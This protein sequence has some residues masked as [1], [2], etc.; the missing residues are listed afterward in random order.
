MKKRFVI[1]YILLNIGIIMGAILVIINLI[2]NIILKFNPEAFYAGVPIGTGLTWLL[3]IIPGSILVR[4]HEQLF[5]T[6]IGAIITLLGLGIILILVAV[7]LSG[8]DP[9]HAAL[10]IHPLV[11]FLTPVILP[12]VLLYLTPGILLIS[13]IK[14]LFI[15]GYEFLISGII[16][17]IVSAFI[18]IQ[19][20]LS[21]PTGSIGAEWEAGFAFLFYKFW[22][23]VIILGSI[24]V[25]KHR[26]FVKKLFAIIVIL[27][28]IIPQIL[29]FVGLLAERLREF[30]RL[31]G[32]HPALPIGPEP[33]LILFMLG[34]EMRVPLLLI[35][36]VLYLV[37][38]ILLLKSSK[39][40]RSG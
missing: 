39:Q 26:F 15:I 28:G 33:E 10:P 29:V 11:L 40:N 37:P 36:F 6:I 19:T 7:F 32:R 13:N 34:D 4:K 18:Y 21:P 16:G 31:R 30:E 3:F 9:G 20:F 1:G 27:L 22:S 24:M 17:A 8:Q 23:I 2:Q 12:L 38:G 35:P 14:S 5:K 25:I